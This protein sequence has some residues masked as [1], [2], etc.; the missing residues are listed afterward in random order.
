[1]KLEL[2]ALASRP[3]WD[4]AVNKVKLAE[5]TNK[6]RTTF[7]VHTWHCPTLTIGVSA[8]EW[9]K[10]H[11]TFNNPVTPLF[12]RYHRI[13]TRKTWYCQRNC[14]VLLLKWFK[15]RTDRCWWREGQIK[16]FQ[17]SLNFQT[18]NLLICSSFHQFLVVL[19]WSNWDQRPDG[20]FRPEALYD[21][22]S[23]HLTI[24]K[25]FVSTPYASR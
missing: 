12:R 22:H 15:G 3:V 10:I 5:S 24:L 16:N 17:S 23:T 19:P 8:Q 25:S 1:M 20:R 6:A 2:R 13:W 4:K 21:S 18:V 14:H 11:T 7:R 9:I